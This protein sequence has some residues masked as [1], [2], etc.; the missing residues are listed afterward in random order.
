MRTK[1]IL[2]VVLVSTAIF[3]YGQERKCTV[4]YRQE[5]FV[6]SDF[7]LNAG[8][9]LNFRKDLDIY[10]FGGYY[11]DLPLAESGKNYFRAGGHISYNLSSTGTYFRI[12]GR[13]DFTVR[14]DYGYFLAMQSLPA[15][16]LS[17][18][19]LADTDGLCTVGIWGQI[20]DCK[21]L[22][23]SAWLH[24]G[25][26]KDRPTLVEVDFVLKF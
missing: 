21:R 12:M 5:I 23:I 1:V 7:T 2:I 11:R 15:F 4:S 16:P 18:T 3:S 22:N 13:H 25:I 10:V 9:N 14:A 20:Y 24:Q 17:P 6:S 8:V 19:F 26:T